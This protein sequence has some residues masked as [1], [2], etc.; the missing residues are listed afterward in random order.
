MEPGSLKS[1]FDLL[2]ARVLDACRTQYGNRLVS[3]AVFGSVG[4]G[5]PR[6][7]SDIDLMIVAHGLPRGRTT[8]MAEFQRVETE[9][10]PWLARARSAGLNPELSP[11]IRTPEEVSRGSLLM[12][13]LTEDARLLYDD[14]GFL[15]T[16]LDRFKNRLREL[17][18]RRIW[19]GNAWYWDLKPDYQPGDI[20]EL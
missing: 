4:R 5:T 9:V 11:V 16:A 1:Q 19:S 10:Q 12:L 6:P 20:F 13:D 7:D 14:Q 17:G 8:R 18:A 3:V 2:L 15:G